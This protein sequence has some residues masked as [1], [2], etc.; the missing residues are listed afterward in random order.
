MTLPDT[1]NGHKLP[2][3]DNFYSLQGEG[4]NTGKPVYFIRLGGCNVGCSWCDSKETWNALKFPLVEVERIA[5]LVKD[6]SAQAV[7]ITGGEPA[8]HNLTPLCE[9]LKKSN[10]EIFLE[11]SGSSPIIGI[12]DWITLS[13]K[14]NKPPL[15]DSFTKASELKVVIENPGDFDWA[16]E[17]KSKVSP[18]CRLYLQP[19]WNNIDKMLPEIVN[20]ALKN[21]EWIVSMQVHKYMNIK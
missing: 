20:F 11:T 9:E 13:P 6:T 19:E 10:L 1:N 7:V 14:K 21:P 16:R 2:L 8:L 4:K 18:E 17:N 3:A 12:F 5:S 15:L